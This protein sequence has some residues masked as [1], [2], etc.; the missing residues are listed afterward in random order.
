LAVEASVEASVEAA[1]EAVEDLAD[2][3]AEAAVLAA[4]EPG[5][6]GKEQLSAFSL[7][8]FVSWLM[9]KS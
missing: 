5:E 3:A 2:S 4:A 7:Q 6:A 8:L 1:A 9:A